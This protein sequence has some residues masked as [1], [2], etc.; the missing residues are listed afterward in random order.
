MESTIFE[1]SFQKTT[2]EYSGIFSVTFE[3]QS[4]TLHNHVTPNFEDS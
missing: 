2:D 3:T 1:K 4:S